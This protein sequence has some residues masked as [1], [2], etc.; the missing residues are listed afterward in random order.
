MHVFL[1]KKVCGRNTVISVKVI[2]QFN[3]ISHFQLSQLHGRIRKSDQAH[4]VPP[5]SYPSRGQALEQ[6]VQR[7]GPEH[8]KVHTGGQQLCP[9]DGAEQL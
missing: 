7:V 1:I 8:V 5:A 2:N 9:V 4:A 3:N 6:H